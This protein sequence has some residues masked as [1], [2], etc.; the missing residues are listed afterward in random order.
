MKA[1]GNGCIDPHLLDLGT[2]WRWV[3]SFTPL[4]LYPGVPPG[5]HLIG[6][7][8]DPRASLDNVKKRKFLTLLGLELR[9][10]DC[11]AH[12]QS[13]YRLHYP[14]SHDQRVGN[15]KWLYNYTQHSSSELKH[16]FMKTIII[17]H[18]TFSRTLSLTISDISDTVSNY[19]SHFN[20]SVWYLL[21]TLYTCTI[22]LQ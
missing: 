12:S 8:V 18:L 16:H 21:Q 19:L 20:L 14:S 6:G 11:P 2:S 10:L 15:N 5:T 7:W 13:L 22:I 4:P 17:C 1:Y 9:S 3:V